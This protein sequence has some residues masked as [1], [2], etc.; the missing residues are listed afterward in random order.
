MKVV[1]FEDELY[2]REQLKRNLQRLKPDYE[3]IYESDSLVEAINYFN[4]VPEVDL[5]F[6]DIELADGNCFDIFERVNVPCPI[7]FTTAYSDFALKA[8]RTDSVDY[9]LKPV[10]ESALLMA[11]NKFE[12]RKGRIES[13]EK[14]SEIKRIL[15]TRGDNYS[16]L[17]INDIAWLQSEDKYVV[18]ITNDGVRHLTSSN[19]L[20]SLSES[21]NAFDFFQLSR[22]CT[23]SFRAIKRV[24]KYFRGRLSITLS[25]GPVNEKVLVSAL[26]RESFLN[27][28][29][30]L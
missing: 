7:I 25:A 3:I 18:A 11:I 23:V 26:R 10:T 24:S 29:A 30:S 22:N 16:A 21:L 4:S 20:A 12:L 6:M 2:A 27:W 14:K 19:N 9:I 28:Y 1:I 15:C 5:A 13:T 17:D 8:F